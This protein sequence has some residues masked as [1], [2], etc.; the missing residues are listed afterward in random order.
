[1][2]AFRKFIQAI[3]ALL[4]MLTLLVVLSVLYPIPYLTPFVANNIF[5]SAD[6]RL[7]IAVVLG[8]LALF[9]LFVFL[10]SCFAPGRSKTLRVMSDKGVLSI[11]RSLIEAKAESAAREVQH[12]RHPKAK[13]R[14]GQEAARTQVA[15]SC[16]VLEGVDEAALVPAIQTAVSAGI[17]HILGAKPSKVDVKILNEAIKAKTQSHARVR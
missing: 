3:A 14:M 12:V 5:K 17:E 2:N 8:I 6:L 11:D 4:V 1:M 13:V 16:Q 15:I 10:Y 7:L 9:S